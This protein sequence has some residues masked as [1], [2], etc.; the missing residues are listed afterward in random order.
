MS[1][2]R[3]LSR[4]R[5]ALVAQLVANGLAQ[6]GATLIGARSLHA[7]IADSPPDLRVIGALAASGAALLALRVHA[8]GIAERL[9]Q[10]YVTRV[11]LRIFEATAARPARAARARAGLTLTRVITD[12]SSLRRWVSD[13]IARSIVAAVTLA[14][15]FFVLVTVHPAAS[16][17]LGAVSLGCAAAAAALAPLLRANVREARRRRG[18]LANN[19][20]EKLLASRTVRQLGRTDAELAR[21]RTHSGWLRDALVRRARVAEALAALPDLATPVALAAWIAL[22]GASEPG[23]LAAGP[24]VLGV[25]GGAL[26]D[27]ARALEHRVA[28]DEGRRRIAELLAAPRLTERRRARALPGSGPLAL[29]LSKVGVAGALA[30]VTFAAKPGERVLVTGPA[31]SGKSTLLALAARLLDPDSGE[32]QLGGEPLRALSLDAVH[33]A[34]QL[35][36]PD[37]PLLRGSVAD[38]VSYGAEDDAAD[39]IEAVALAC[40]LVDDP[41]LAEGVATRVEE[42]G[43]NLSAS[44]RAR[45]ALARAVAMRP[46]LL[47]VDDPAFAADAGARDALQRALALHPVTALVVGAEG[48]CGFESTQTWKLTRAPDG[49]A[50]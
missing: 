32:L 25:L 36:S 44:L 12:L 6:A 43:A 47:L 1:F 21:V 50:A 42:R 27:L 39:W 3:V 9:G 8:G 23:E 40:G 38:N 24:L 49:A 5:R 15:A 2:P 37:L 13:G 30:S 26:R 46:R 34:V 16:L 31:G 28:F 41:A 29:E 19:L 11:R 33:D 18:R 35:V 17:A 22:R 48:V 14:G 45:I 20:G 10:D 7:A 4:R